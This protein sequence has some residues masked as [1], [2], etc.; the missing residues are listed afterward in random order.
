MSMTKPAVLFT[1]P[2]QRGWHFREPMG[3]CPQKWAFEHHPDLQTEPEVIATKAKDGREPLIKGSLV[4]VGL[5]HVYARRQA[6]QQGWDPGT[7]A[8]PAEAIAE[9]AR[10]EDDRMSHALGNPGPWGKW[11]TLAQDVVYAYDAQT[12]NE[13]ENVIAVEHS[14]A[15]TLPRVS[16][17]LG[18]PASLYTARADLIIQDRAQRYWILDHKST[19]RVDQK[20]RKGF[21]LS[22]QILGLYALGR[23]F[24]GDAF[25]GVRLNMIGLRPPY[26]F[27][28]ITPAPAPW[29]MAQFEQV[30][31]DRETKLSKLLVET[32]EGVR[33]VWEWPKALSEMFCVHRYGVC[34][35][36]DLCRWGP[37]RGEL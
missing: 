9:V 11:V 32:E 36:H 16:E 3:T 27:T 37:P 14:L 15:M 1:G 22:G 4:H 34:S 5:A 19:Y 18:E 8:T 12:Y 20:K 23:H 13:N 24:Y 21:V 28:R 7:V 26:Q 6:R 35:F 30:V 17:A 2:S 31:L 25:G 10:L 33:T 29:A